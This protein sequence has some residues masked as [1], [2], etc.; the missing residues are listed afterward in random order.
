MA[1]SPTRGHYQNPDS[2]PPFFV[3]GGLARPTAAHGARGLGRYPLLSPTL[4]RSQKFF[5][6]PAEENFFRQLVDLQ[7]RG[8]L[9][10]ALVAPAVVAA[11][12]V[13]PP[14]QGG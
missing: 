9:G 14:Q 12:L 7:V 6:S 10:R 1:L 13:Q 4:G 8:G 5:Q 11:T 3:V 2:P